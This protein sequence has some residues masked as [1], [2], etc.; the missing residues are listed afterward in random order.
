[1]RGKFYN[2]FFAILFS[3]LC[4]GC[5]EEWLEEP[6]SNTPLGVFDAIWDEYDKTYGAFEVKNINW[7]SCRMKYRIQL[8]SESSNDKLYA[9]VCSLLAELKDGHVQLLANG[10]KRFYAVP[11]PAVFPDSRYYENASEIAL[12]F[13]LVKNRY[14]FNAKDS[15]SFFY[16]FISLRSVNKKIGYLYVPGF[17]RE[18]FSFEFIDQA[19]R[20][21]ASCDGIIID[22]RF[23]GGGSSDVLSSFINRY[24]DCE[25]L[26]LLSKI[27]NGAR[28]GDFTDF[29]RHYMRPEAVNI[30]K[31][32]L[33]VLVNRHTASSA[34]HF[35]LAMR[36][37][38]N[39]LIVGDSTIGALSTVVQRM[40]PNGWEY[41]TCPQVLY[42]T[43]GN[44]L[45]NSD[46]QYPDGIGLAPD[47]FV[48]NYLREIYRGYDRVLAT[49]LNYYEEYFSEKIK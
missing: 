44:I 45:R 21:F 35:V 23:N 27:R 43:T 47:L 32:P 1:M 48:K 9:V 38:P 40:A 29:I 10:Y 4:G 25:R 34:E 13:D 31:T 22:L 12:L 6:Y 18:S 42:D 24:A 5:T 8:T 2:V 11:L 20:S 39:T 30:G 41:R 36:T 33:I 15:G 28:H 16:G 14:L 3:F 49:A 26:F 17:D 7:D 46:G 19:Q 37:R